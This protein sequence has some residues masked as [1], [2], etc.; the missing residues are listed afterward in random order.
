MENMYWPLSKLAMFYEY[1]YIYCIFLP[2]R[3]N[4]V[5][6]DYLVPQGGLMDRN[7]IYLNRI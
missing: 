3:P 4:F 1:A 7:L 2:C 6:I 5:V